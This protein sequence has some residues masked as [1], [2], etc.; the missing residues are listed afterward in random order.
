MKVPRPDSAVL[1]NGVQSH[2]V[3]ATSQF[4][5]NYQCKERRNQKSVQLTDNDRLTVEKVDMKM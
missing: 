2:S 1:F 5:T 4:V 3:Q